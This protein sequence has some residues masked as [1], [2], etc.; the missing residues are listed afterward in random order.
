MSLTV[1]QLIADLKA[2]KFA[3]VYLLTGEEN[4]FIDV[5]SDYMEEHV[6]APEFQDFDKTV[7]YGRDVDM[8]T[9][10]ATAKR[11]PMMSPYQLVLVKEAQD[12][13]TR[14]KAWDFLASYLEHPQM[15]TVLVF[16]HRHKKL[17]KRSKAYKAI[18]AKGVVFETK[19]MRESELYNWIGNSV[20]EHGYSIP[21]KSAMLLAEYLGSDLGKINNELSKLYIALP[22]GTL[23]G[24]EVIEQ[25]VGISKDYNIFELQS[26]LS[27]R[28]VEKSN[29]IIN[30]F[31][32]NPKDNPIQLVLP[33]LY[34]YFI[35]VMIYIQDPSTANPY[36]AADLS[37]AAHN[38]N[39]PKLARV[40]GYLYE[41]DLKSKG[42][43]NSNTTPDGEILKEMVFKIIH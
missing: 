41:A 16:C 32:A 34:S 6:V 23:F 27:R 9:V 7:L 36:M 15:Q 19:K 5:V 40:I 4:Y 3:P 24:G 11:Y 8:K 26:A 39:L 20:K 28:D 17:D 33:M 35:K 1:K 2:G 21:E 37:A 14:D 10:V 30:N 38:Y 43:K 25:Y 42:V 31:A 12:I 29:R 22:K 18:N 13:P